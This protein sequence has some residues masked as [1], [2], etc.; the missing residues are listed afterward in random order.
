MNQKTETL[1]HQST[2]EFTPEFVQVLVMITGATLALVFIFENIFSRPEF[3]R[4]VP[5]TPFPWVVA[6]GYTIGDGLSMFSGKVPVPMPMSGRI[7]VMISLLVTFVVGPTLFFFGWRHRRLQGEAGRTTPILSLWTLLFILGGM[8]TFSATI[9]AIP[10][11]IMQ[12][13]VSYNLR[14]AQAVQHNKDFIINDLNMIAWNARQ[15]RILPKV[16]SGG[17]GSFVGYS[18]PNVLASTE[19]ATYEVVTSEK[20]CAIKA[21]SRIYP[22]AT[23]STKV[24]HDGRLWDWS[25]EGRFQ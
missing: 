3:L 19:N 13:S 11:A 16:M 2:A 25:Y 1:G 5:M 20:E 21:T 22:A 18:L 4:E 23:V 15:Y 6:A 8:L 7:I 24:K 9:P 14:E 10:V 17:D 12:R